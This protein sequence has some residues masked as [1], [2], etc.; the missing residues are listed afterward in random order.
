[1][2][3]LDEKAAEL[4]QAITAEEAGINTKFTLADAIRLGSMVSTHNQGG[5]GDGESACAMT[6]AAIAAKAFGYFE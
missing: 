5:W 6:A 3:K 4:T 2:S 1:M